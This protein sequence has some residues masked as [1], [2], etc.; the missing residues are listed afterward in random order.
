MT[1]DIV[2]NGVPYNISEGKFLC[3]DGGKNGRYILKSLPI[4]EGIAVYQEP[5]FFGGP[6][7]DVDDNRYFTRE[8]MANGFTEGNEPPTPTYKIN[9]GSTNVLLGKIIHGN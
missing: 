8:E 2:D 6:Y 3:L 4:G 7:D 5:K 1:I 9:A